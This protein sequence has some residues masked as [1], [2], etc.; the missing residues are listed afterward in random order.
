MMKEKLK[1]TVYLLLATVIWGSA[2]IAQSVGMDHVGPF[3][4]Q[5]VR[6]GLAC[7][8]LFPLSRFTDGKAYFGQKWMNP[9]LWKTGTL[10]GLAL[11]LAAGLQQVS[12]QYTSAG[13]AG[14]LTAM[15]IVL[16]PV[17]G[18]YLGKKPSV[19][20]W[21]SVAIAVL[22]LYLLS[23]ANLTGIQPADLML[24]G[25]AFFFAV[26]ITIVDRLGLGFD[27]VRLNCVQS[28]VCAVLSAIMMALT[29][30]VHLGNILRCWLP[31]CYAGILSMGVAYTLQ[32]IGQQK[33]EPTQASIL[34][35]L[36]SVFA[37]LF[38]W[39][40]LKERLSPVELAGCGAM[41]C[42][43]VL[44]QIPKKAPQ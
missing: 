37:L 11:F 38:G 10:A 31:L 21:I 35:S 22:G 2:F 19:T 1:G 36:E 40:I 41:F 6:C 3:T 16:V 25:C 18:V 17:L 26:Q 33:L 4:F 44:S 29:E 12:L 20:V 15:Y 43:V 42:A 8:F 28:L 13:K 23:G 27:G 39:V 5:A 30:E 24:L 32:I 14:F 7:L 34:M 9:K